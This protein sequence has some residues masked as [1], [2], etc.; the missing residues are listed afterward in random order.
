MNRKVFLSILA[1][2]SYQRGYSPGINGILGNSIGSATIVPRESVGISDEKYS[3]WQI[4]GFYASAYR[5]GA[6]TVL[7]YRGTDF[8]ITV[9]VYFTPKYLPEL[10]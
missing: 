1:M 6:E 5:W 7:S 3:A 10:R 2:D 8:G 4:D 9:T